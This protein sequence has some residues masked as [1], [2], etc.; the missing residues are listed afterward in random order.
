MNTPLSVR[1]METSPDPASDR[2]LL[3]VLLTYVTSTTHYKEYRIIFGMKSKQ[4]TVFSLSPTSVL[5]SFIV[6]T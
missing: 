5:I 4:L 3:Q 2:I 6:T 1:F